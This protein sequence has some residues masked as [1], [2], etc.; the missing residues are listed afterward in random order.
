MENTPTLDEV[1]SAAQVL[2]A[3]IDVQTLQNGTELPL[4]QAAIDA[5]I[6]DDYTNFYL[7]GLDYSQSELDAIYARLPKIGRASCRERVSLCV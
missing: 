4:M 2:L 1:K 3:N 7:R 5:V 6:P